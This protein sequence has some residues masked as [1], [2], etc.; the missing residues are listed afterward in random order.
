MKAIRL[1]ILVIAIW[2]SSL[3]NY[4]QQPILIHSHND[5][6]QEVPFYE[7][8]SSH[9]YSIEADIF[10]GKDNQ[11]L[12]AH[13]PNS[14]NANFTFEE[15]Y[16]RP[17]LK[18][19]QLNKNH[20]WRNQKDKMQLLVDIKTSCAPTLNSLVKVLKEH[21][22]VFDCNVNPFAVKV[23]ISGNT[24]SPDTFSKY[25]DFISFDGNLEVK[26]TQPELKRI[27]F[28]SDDL[29]KYTSWN[30]KGGI[31]EPELK[32]IVEKINAAH[33]L[34]K[35]IR[36]W[37]TPDGVTA[38]NT[39]HN[40]GVD[41]IGTDEPTKCAAFFEHRER[42]IYSLAL[43]NNSTDSIARATRLD[44]Q[45]ADFKGFNQ[46]KQFLSKGIEV[47]HPT[48][49]SDGVTKK[50]KNVIVLIGDGMGLAQ[51]CAAYT[52]NGDLNVFQ[53]KNIGFIKTFAK[54]YYTTDSAAGGSALATGVKT[55]NRYISTNPNGTVNRTICEVLHQSGIKCGVVT[56]SD[57]AD[58]TPAAFYGHS[59]ERDNADE[60]TSW[61]THGALDLLC[62]TGMKALTKRNDGLN[63]MSRLKEQYLITTDIGAIDKTPK[64]TICIT[65]EFEEGTTAKTIDLL[66]E[67]TIKSINKLN[68]ENQSGFFLMIEG[69]KIDWAGHANSLPAS[70]LENLNFDAAVAAAMKFADEDGET[71]IIVTADHETGGLNIVDGNTEKHEVVGSYMTHD[72][73]PIMVPIYAYGPGSQKFTGVYQNT[74]VYDKILKCMG[75][76]RK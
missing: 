22:D 56:T 51:S 38:W 4:A 54:D 28:F 40:I 72:H 34:N 42:K 36:F 35:P 59:T 3:T 47:Y 66:K 6:L 21:T 9:I 74:E 68:S 1:V 46:N 55:N 61:L 23:V 71:L 20:P 29:A 18:A 32:K 5:Y 11:L 50:A 45:T 26:Y 76:L 30:G 69:G 64:K 37:S 25:P 27:A 43:K 49:K 16:L 44:K 75:Q 2:T 67:V 19:F 12:V 73:T 33:K 52:V 24:P 8:Y 48:Y 65:Q 57:I 15:L 14:I 13:T 41:I 7:A 31:K 70:I 10:L 39:L 53:M 63:L 62:G 17:I 60:I 58:A